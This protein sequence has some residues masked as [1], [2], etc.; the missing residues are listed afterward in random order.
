MLEKPPLLP[1]KKPLLHHPV[2]TSQS[3]PKKQPLLGAS[4]ERS[5]LKAPWSGTKRVY[6]AEESI[7]ANTSPTYP[8]PLKRQALL[9]TPGDWGCVSSKVDNDQNQTASGGLLPRPFRQITVNQTGLLP[10]PTA[11]SSPRNIYTPPPSAPPS[12]PPLETN[13]P[14][15]HP[16]PLI[17]TSALSPSSG[18]LPLPMNRH[19]SSRNVEARSVSFKKAPLLQT[20]CEGVLFTASKK[21]LLPLI[22]SMTCVPQEKINKSPLLKAPSSTSA[23]HL[24]HNLNSI[25]SNGSGNSSNSNPR[26]SREPLIS[27]PPPSLSSRFETSTYAYKKSSA[28]SNYHQSP[29]NSAS[30]KRPLLPTPTLLC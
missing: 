14:P 22:P 4:P 12:L 16:T 23:N 7:S 9:P 26:F 18:L 30:I 13:K 15:L 28:S 1:I 6:G 29:N 8:S 17:P 2:D 3:Q 11:C 27:T 19:E 10:P 25:P 20:P 24:Q 5:L 21:P